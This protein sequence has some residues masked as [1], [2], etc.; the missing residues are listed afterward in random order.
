MKR[1][2]HYILASLFLTL[3]ALSCQS[4]AEKN[5]TEE[6]SKASKTLTAF[7]SGNH[8]GYKNDAGKTVIPAKFDGVYTE[9]FETYAIVRTGTDLYTIDAKGN[10]KYDV[11]WFDNGPDY[12]KEN[13]FRYNDK[14][15]GGMGFLN[16]QTGAIAVE[17]KFDFVQPFSEGR[18]A[19]CIGGKSEQMGEHFSWVGGKWG[20]IDTTGKVVITCEYD[21]VTSFM[22]GTATVWKGGKAQIIDGKGMIR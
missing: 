7:E 22:E 18:A 11:Y 16:G 1:P 13:R 3:G 19:V 20:F 4:T 8:F 9:N 10:R 14:T 21:E 17:A 6:S 12:I 15:S 5:A 2:T